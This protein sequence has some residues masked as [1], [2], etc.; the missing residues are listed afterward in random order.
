[1]LFFLDI[2]K[3][4][5]VLL[6]NTGDKFEVLEHRFFGKKENVFEEIVDVE[7]EFGGRRESHGHFFL[8]SVHKLVFRRVGLSFERVGVIP[9]VHK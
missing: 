3:F 7:I 1:M 5:M 9:S 6:E 2:Q 8:L 4:F